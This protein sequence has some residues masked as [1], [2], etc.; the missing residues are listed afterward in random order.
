MGRRG[1]R[2]AQRRAPLPSWATLTDRTGGRRGLPPAPLPSCTL[3]PAQGQWPWGTLHPTPHRAAVPAT[4]K[5][6]LKRN[7]A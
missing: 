4:A 6:T 3:S 5:V 2:R 1:W 7:C